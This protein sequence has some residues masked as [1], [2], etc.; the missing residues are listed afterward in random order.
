LPTF[1]RLAREGRT[2]L[3]DPVAPGVVPD[4]AAGSLAIFGQSPRAIRRGPVEA[5]GA[6]I[7][8][9]PGDIAL[10][11][12]FATLDEAGRVIDRR[13]GRIREGTDELAEALDRVPFA[14]AR[15][16]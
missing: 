4:T 12:N 2:G 16:E 8:L 15:D 10:R 7:D 6:G 3:G 5:L 1:D 11:A 13:A 9:A 14:E